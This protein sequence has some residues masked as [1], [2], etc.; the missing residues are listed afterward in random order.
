MHKHAERNANIY[1]YF[2]KYGYIHADFHADFKPVAFA[3]A[4]IISHRDRDIYAKSD[5]H[6]IA[7]IHKQPHRDK[8]R[9]S[10]RDTDSHALWRGF[11]LGSAGNRGRKYRGK[12]NYNNLHSRA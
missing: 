4:V 2:A 9:E 7:D 1:K 10:D 12:Y 5:I 8:H 3:D 11:S 6:D